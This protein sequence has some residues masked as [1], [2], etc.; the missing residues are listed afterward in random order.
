MA[1]K[2]TDLKQLVE[3]LKSKGLEGVG[4]YYSKG[5]PSGVKLSKAAAEKLF[6]LLSKK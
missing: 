6:A 2:Q 1:E 5:G 4:L 3:Q